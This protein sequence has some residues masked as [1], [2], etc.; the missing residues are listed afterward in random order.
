[1]KGLSHTV[2][3]QLFSLFCNHFYHNIVVEGEEEAD[4]D[5]GETEASEQGGDVTEHL[6]GPHPSVLAQRDL[7][8]GKIRLL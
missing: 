2:Y 1:M 7:R 3:I 8:R 5:H 4:N 6:D